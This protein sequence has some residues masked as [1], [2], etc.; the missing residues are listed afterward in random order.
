MNT[1]DKLHM[2]KQIEEDNRKHVEEWKRKNMK[3]WVAEFAFI[4]RDGVKC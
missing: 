1:L 2:M 4:D 3:I